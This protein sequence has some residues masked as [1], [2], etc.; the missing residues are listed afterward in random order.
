MK[1]IQ[2]SSYGGPELMRVEDFRL[3][4]PGKG[5]VSVQV[6]LPRPLSFTAEEIQALVRVIGT[7]DIATAELL[8]ERYTSTAA[9]SSRNG[10]SRR[11]DHAIAKGAFAKKLQLRPSTQFSAT[12]KPRDCQSALRLWLGI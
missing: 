10:A 2:Y 6:K 5:E 12:S 8:V 7:D 3:P 11:C 1:R 9:S 4:A